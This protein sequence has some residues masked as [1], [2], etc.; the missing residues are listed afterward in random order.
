MTHRSCS[1]HPVVKRTVVGVGA[2]RTAS[3]PGTAP[4][5]S[6][7]QLTSP[8]AVVRNESPRLPAEPTVIGPPE[9]LLPQSAQFG[10]P[11]AHLLAPPSNGT[12]SDGGVGSGSGGG[13]GSG[14]GPGVGPGWG[15]GIG[16]GVYHVGGGVTAPRPL[17]EP[18]PEYS[19]EARKA[20]YQGSVVLDV[21]V[22]PD[23]RPHNLRVLRSVGMGLDEKAIEAVQ[24][25]KFAPATK[26]GQ[27]VAVRVSIEVAFRLY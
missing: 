20:K 27:P 3:V 1:R 21:I 12:G 8:A 10:D 11:L 26:D 14:Y 17:F 23:G 13:V 4:R 7:E 5:F 22:G 15:G 9:V 19:E 6:S 25:W 18:D 24:R 2:I 16:G